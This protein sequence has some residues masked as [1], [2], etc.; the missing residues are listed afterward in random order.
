[1]AKKIIGVL[2][3]LTAIFLVVG[4][5]FNEGNVIVSA[6]VAVIYVLSGVFFFGFDSV[7]RL[8][9]AQGVK[10]RKTQCAVIVLFIVAYALL[11]GMANMGAIM[12][13]SDGFG[14]E[15]W[16][17]MMPYVIPLI[18]F[19]GLLG[20]Y[21]VPFWACQR[22]VQVD[23]TAVNAPLQ[24][25][26]EKSGLMANDHV[27]YF[28]KTFCPVPFEQIAS[29][30]FKNLGIEQDMYIHLTNGKKIELVASRRVYEVV[31]TAVEAHK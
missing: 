10:R 24:M 18:A 29:V 17:A 8:T 5:V 6:I 11:F 19:G 2:F 1:M 23:V 26:D 22:Q 3:F 7:N 27:I 9:Y 13:G 25:L 12:A 20:M 31:K 28:S 30:E 16:I 14:W 21:A 15:Y 4:S